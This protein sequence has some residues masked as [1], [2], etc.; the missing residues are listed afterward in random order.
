MIIIAVLTISL[1][2]TLRAVRRPD[3]AA[4][5]AHHTPVRL[6]GTAAL[7]PSMASGLRMA[8]DP[9]RGPTAVPVRS[10]CFGAVLGVI[11]IV[12]VLVFGASLDHLTHTPRLSGFTFDFTVPDNN[13][14][15]FAST[16]DR[17]DFGIHKIRGVADVAAVCDSDIQL[18]GRPITAFGVTPI[19]GEIAPDIVEGRAPRA[20]DEVALGSTTLGEIHKH[21]GDTVRGPKP[22]AR[23][24]RIVGTVV[25]PTLAYPQPLADGA[26]F[27]SAG[28]HEVFDKNSRGSR[29]IIGRFT[30]GANR[31][32]VLTEVAAR[33]ARTSANGPAVPIEVEHV[34]DVAWIP[35]T[36]AVLLAALALVGVG[37]ALM[38]ATRR[39]RRELAMLKTLGFVRSQVRATVA[40]QATILAAIGLVIG[41]PLGVILGRFA[42]HLVA[43]GL[44]VS[45][46]YAISLG[47]LILVPA[48][49]LAVNVLAFIPARRAA[50]IQPGPALRL[51]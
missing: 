37:H 46:V 41:M 28:L 31:A 36:L 13:F 42:W 49:L 43:D 17:A 18:D 19:R 44:G 2:A 25:L 12:A 9:G 7:P 29:N 38:T 11:G 23:S 22:E 3:A 30:R 35:R 14:S 21:I 47:A 32:V 20:H 10:A 27:T 5:L 26:L 4:V 15:A 45:T 24:Y 6:A 33:Q 34:R 16:C 1:I 50:R 51:E 8:L 48:A 39:R 40:W